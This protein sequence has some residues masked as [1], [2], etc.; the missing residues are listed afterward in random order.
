MPRILSRGAL[1]PSHRSRG[2][3]VQLST[4]RSTDHFGRSYSAGLFGEGPRPRPRRRPIHLSTDPG[5]SIGVKFPSSELFQTLEERRLSFPYEDDSPPPSRTTS[6]FSLF[7]SALFTYQER[8]RRP[9]RLSS[10]LLDVF[11]TSFHIRDSKSDQ[12]SHTAISGYSGSS[13]SSVPSAAPTLD[14]G[15]HISSG[16]DPSDSVSPLLYTGET[17]DCTE[18]EDN[19]GFFIDVAAGERQMDEYKKIYPR[20]RVR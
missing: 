2:S 3:M 16:S 9:C 7:G 19:W 18:K 10:S 5:N 14:D 17:R 1:G 4:E 11:R 8:E 12:P 15:S 6:C 20:R 13:G